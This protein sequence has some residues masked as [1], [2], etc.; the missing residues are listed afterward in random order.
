MLLSLVVIC[1]T[2]GLLIFSQTLAYY[3]DEAFHLLASQLIL[4]GKTPYLDFFYPQAPLYAYWTAACMRVFGDSWR[5]A[6]VFSALLTSAAIALLPGFIR[7]V[8]PEARW[9]I[10]IAITAVLLAGLN[11]LLIRFGTIG[12]AYGLCLFLIAAAFRLAVKAADSSARWLPVWAGICAGAAAASSLLCAPVVPILLAWLLRY[13]SNTNRLK[14]GARFAGGAAIPFLPLFWFALRAPRQTLFNVIEYHLLYRKV[15]YPHYNITLADLSVLS[16]WLSSPQGLLLAFL[17]GLGVLSIAASG[18]WNEASRRN[19]YLCIWLGAGLGAYLA[20][21][22]PTFPQY[23]VLLIPFFSILASVGVYAVGSRIC[24]SIRPAPLALA[25]IGLFALGLAK[26]AY[27]QRSELHSLWPEIEQIGR[28]VDQVTPQNGLICAD[29]AIYVAAHRAP[30]PGLEHSDAH[31]LH[32]SP[33]LA[34]LLRV[35]PFAERDQWISEGRFDTV[36]MWFPSM[37]RVNMLG[38]PRLYAKSTKVGDCLIYSGRTAA[39][40]RLPARASAENSASL[41]AKR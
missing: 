7:A 35:I 26:S 21:P 25:A 30:P 34:S 31:K 11:L 10:P 23:F 20:T 24:P 39:S 2:A 36:V 8:I 18:E 28:A 38:L 17:S 27:R 1:L 19:L 14:N 15:G 13:G 22:H 9:R 16:G 4:L 32:L 33:P 37:E 6:H 41:N 3:G 29:E 5:T 40:G 12:Q